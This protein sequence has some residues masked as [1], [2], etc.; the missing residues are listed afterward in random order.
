VESFAERLSSRGRADVQ[1]FH[2][3]GTGP[4]QLDGRG[5]WYAFAEIGT[6]VEGI[7]QE[8]GMTQYIAVY[9]AFLKVVKYA[10]PNCRIKVC[11]DSQLLQRHF[12]RT[13]GVIDPDLCRLMG[14]ARQ[15]LE[16]KG[17]SVK[18]KLISRSEN[19][20]AAYLERN[21]KEE[22]PPNLRRRKASDPP[23]GDIES[24]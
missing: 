8:D 2:V 16:D 21:E 22:W 14:K 5:S 9:R 3:A 10:P 18:F 6:G 24:H 1:T 7:R 4:K 11:T 15:I 12:D 23:N 20:A 17:I 13:Y 19:R